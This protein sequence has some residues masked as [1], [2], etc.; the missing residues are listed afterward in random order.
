MSSVATVPMSRSGA[1][2]P[3]TWLTSGSVKT[4]TT[5]QIASVSRMW[6][7]NWLPR[8]CPSDA[9]RTSPAMSTNRTVAGTILAESYSP[10]SAC[11]RGSGMPTMPIFG[12]IVANG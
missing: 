1:T 6:A 11:S 10:A 4:L 9:P 3:S 12:S 5:W 7:R 8:P 2:S